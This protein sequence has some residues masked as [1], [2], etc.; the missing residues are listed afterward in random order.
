MSSSAAGA[1]RLALTAALVLLAALLT[2]HPAAAA[3]PAIGAPAAFLVE[4][5][6]GD[7]LLSRRADAERPVASTTKLMTALL[8]LERL[9]L[10]DV[11][12]QVPYRG[13][14]AESIA[15][16][17][18]GERVTVRDEVRALLV[19]SANDAA[20]TIAVRTAGS[21]RRFVALMNAR[22][23]ALGLRHT[24]Y[25]NPIGLDDP[26]NFSSAGDL[27]KLALV[28]RTHAFFR[29]T[30]DLPRVTLRS[31]AVRRTLVNR[32][33]LVAAVPAVD[34]VKTG[35][36]RRAGYVLVGSATR[37][38]VTVVSAVLGTPSEAA[39]NTDTL[40]LLRYGLARYH[41][42]T[43]VRRGERLA[44][45]GLR[46][47]EGIVRLVA[48]RAVVRTARRGERLRTAVT[49][50]PAELDGPL[51]RGTPVATVTVRQRGRVV[52]RVPL[53]TDRAIAEAGLTDRLRDAGG[54]PGVILLAAALVAGSL[55]LLVLRRRGARRTP[56]DAVARSRDTEVA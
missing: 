51:P 19:A 43:V 50:V 48:T 55:L 15:G 49:G 32:N 45:T 22:A 35:H 53:V 44:S 29:A 38:G 54:R 20:N 21:S 14:P 23:R 1:R 13:A 27:V 18:G 25:A 4:P 24:H 40:A 41:R 5:A 12:V 30:T 39:R 28:L 16:F 26:Q 34:G 31:G 2:A 6:T 3:A 8:A 52:A 47:R 11:L 33:T 9:D 17:R 10:D 42:V 36:T 46:F 56:P 37:R 7:V